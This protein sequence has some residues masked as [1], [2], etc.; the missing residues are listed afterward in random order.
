MAVPYYFQRENYSEPDLPGCVVGLHLILPLV[1]LIVCSN[2]L[3][4]GPEIGKE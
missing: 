4:I 3:A 1:P 2:Q